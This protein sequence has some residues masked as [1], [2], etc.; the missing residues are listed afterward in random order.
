[1][2]LRHALRFRA[3]S[4]LAILILTPMPHRCETW[5]W[6]F[7]GSSFRSFPY[8]FLRLAPPYKPA[9]HRR[10]PHSI[11]AHPVVRSHAVCH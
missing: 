11:S 1:M 10:V 4:V 3:R 7:L 6:S 2:A 8:F 5:W 9:E